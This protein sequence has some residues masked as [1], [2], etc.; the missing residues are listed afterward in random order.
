MLL[1]TLA[2]WFDL[3]VEHGSRKSR[4]LMYLSDILFWFS[5]R[6]RCH[7]GM[8]DCLYATPAFTSRTLNLALF[9]DGH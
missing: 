9:V 6:C 8:L 1:E 3:N 2:L 7:A 5:G 4:L